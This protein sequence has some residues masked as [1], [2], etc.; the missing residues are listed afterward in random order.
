MDLAREMLNEEPEARSR[1]DRFQRPMDQ[2]LDEWSVELG[3]DNDVELA[4]RLG[5]TK[6]TI[7]RWRKNETK[8][9]QTA[10]VRYEQVISHYKARM[11]A[12]QKH[13]K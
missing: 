3:V 11:Q 8:P 4:G 6:M 2:I 10:L 12:I 9:D 5:V 13:T 7:Y 1:R